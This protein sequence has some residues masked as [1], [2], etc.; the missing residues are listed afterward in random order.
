MTATELIEE[1][2][3]LKPQTRIVIRGYE[4]GYNDVL[5][6]LPVKIKLNV[7]EHWYEGAHDNSTETDAVDAIDLNG[8]N[9]NAK[10]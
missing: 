5:K 2:Q 8:E 7:N 9:K 4:S 1:L 3:K 10:D 6:L